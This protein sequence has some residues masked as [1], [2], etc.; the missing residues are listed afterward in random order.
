L[1]ALG[2]S[3]VQ[4]L[5]LGDKVKLSQ[6]SETAPGAH[7]VDVPGLFHYGKLL[8]EAADQGNLNEIAYTESIIHLATSSTG[9]SWRLPTKTFGGI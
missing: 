9:T 5:V 2:N 8:L 1:L 4:G 7:I 6:L 3:H